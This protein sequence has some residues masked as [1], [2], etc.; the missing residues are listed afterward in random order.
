MVKNVDCP[1]CEKGKL[2]FNIKNGYKVVFEG[3]MSELPCKIY[4]KN[5]RRS[6]KY[7]VVKEEN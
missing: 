2:E 3:K 5:C 4:C 1:I 6:I 7:K